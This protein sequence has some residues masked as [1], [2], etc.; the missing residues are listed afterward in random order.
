MKIISEA[1]LDLPEQGSLADC[2]GEIMTDYRTM[3]EYNG[4]LF[5]SDGSIWSCWKGRGLGK[6]KGM[7]YSMSPNW[8]RLKLILGEDGYLKVNLRKSSGGFARNSRVHALILAAFGVSKPTTKHEIRHEDRNPTNNRL[9]NLSWGTRKDNA[10]D[11]VRHGSLYRGGT[12]LKR[13]P[14]VIS[15]VKGLMSAGA[16]RKGIAEALS[17]SRGTVS[18]AI[19]SIRREG[20]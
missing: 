6:G 12:R 20:N 1:T 4:Y 15:A 14:A 3:P 19:R 13:T 7:V 8:K 16:T 17:L 18:R 2:E 10:Q 5:G 9:D 11:A